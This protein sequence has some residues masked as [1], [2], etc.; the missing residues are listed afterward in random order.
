MT[1]EQQFIE[2]KIVESLKE[3][4]SAMERA[5]IATPE[6]TGYIYC[7]IFKEAMKYA[8]LPESAFRTTKEPAFYLAYKNSNKLYLTSW[9]DRKFLTYLFKCMRFTGYKYNKDYFSDFLPAQAAYSVIRLAIWALRK[10]TTPNQVKKGIMGATNTLNAI[11]SQSAVDY[12]NVITKSKEDVL[13]DTENNFVNTPIREIIYFRLG[14]TNFYVIFSESD[15]VFIV[16][17]GNKDITKTIVKTGKIDS[18]DCI[19]LMAGDFDLT[20]Q[21]MEAL[22]MALFGEAI[23]QRT[24]VRHEIEKRLKKAKSKK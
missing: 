17:N 19:N 9:D 7:D 6:L 24:N 3:A 23:F 18:N 1:N 11:I 4:V 12:Y 14:T 2:Q 15:Y 10:L 8:S 5:I 13:K 20:P 21:G 22:E 16:D